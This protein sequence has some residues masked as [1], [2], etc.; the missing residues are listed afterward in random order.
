MNKI[1][2]DLLKFVKKNILSVTELTRSTKLTEIL[3][4][5]AA[6]EKNT[7]IYIV[8]NNKVK[9][10]QAVIIDL[11]YFEELLACKEAIENSKKER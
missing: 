9:N 10:A 7:E 11:K 4:S 5:Y 2:T 1:N 3:N 6:T 8:Q